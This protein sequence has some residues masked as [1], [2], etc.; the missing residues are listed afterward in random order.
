[1][2]LL[3]GTHLAN[4]TTVLLIFSLP[5]A[6]LGDRAHQG[7]ATDAYLVLAAF[8]S[9]AGFLMSILVSARGSKAER[10]RVV[11]TWA[12]MATSLLAWHYLESP[13]KI[14]FAVLALLVALSFSAGWFIKAR[15]SYTA[16]SSRG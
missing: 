8:A 16:P 13:A 2:R 6:H 7:P 9:F 15:S 11:A 4:A 5:F 14:V 12:S 1:M 10:R 3:A